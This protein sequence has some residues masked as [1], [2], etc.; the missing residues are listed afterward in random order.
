MRK[1]LVPIAIFVT[2]CSNGIDTEQKW[3]NSMSQKYPSS[4]R[5]I[6]LT[7]LPEENEYTLAID[8]KPQNIS[9]FKG[10]ALDIDEFLH[11]HPTRKS[12]LVI[13]TSRLNNSLIASIFTNAHAF[14]QSLKW[15]HYNYGA[16]DVEPGAGIKNIDPTLALINK[17]NFPNLYHFAAVLAGDQK[18]NAQ[19]LQMLKRAIDT[20]VSDKID[21]DV[22][23]FDL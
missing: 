4:V 22:V 12:V 23:T 2:A 5:H 10:I 20:D 1:V 3:A 19:N 14:R 8:L 21:V 9:D 15:I 16:Q 18:T 6:A 17:R 13:D 7:T 11:K